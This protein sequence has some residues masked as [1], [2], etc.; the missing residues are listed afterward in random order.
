MPYWEQQ[1]QWYSTVWEP[2]V[3]FD[4][5]SVA[6]PFQ[7]LFLRAPVPWFRNKW[8]LFRN[9]DHFFT[10]MDPLNYI[11]MDFPMTEISSPGRQ[12]L[13][14]LENFCSGFFERRLQGWAAAVSCNVSF[15][16]TLPHWALHIMRII[17]WSL[18]VGED[19]AIQSAQSA[20]WHVLEL[21]SLKGCSEEDL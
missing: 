5:T 2:Q 14:S 15:S 6:L 17:S 18:G 1:G 19:R 20:P 16:F 12:G 4:M 7:T 3:L 13:A 10:T 8:N 21:C 11:T 9:L